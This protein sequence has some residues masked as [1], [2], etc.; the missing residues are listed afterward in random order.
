VPHDYIELKSPVK[1]R[2][3]RLTNYHVPDGKFA[4]SGL[5]VF[6][7]GNGKMVRQVSSFTAQ[8]DSADARNVTISWVGS[9]GATGYNIRYGTAPDKL[10]LNYQV[11]DSNTVTIHSLSRLQN[12]YFTIDTFNEHG[13]TK[14]KVTVKALAN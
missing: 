3:I 7:Q 1:A 2:Y 10:Y 4:L 5:R 8:R 14:G 9:P 12:Y 11:L 13:I 6:G